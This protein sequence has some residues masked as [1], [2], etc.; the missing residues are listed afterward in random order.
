MPKDYDY[1][2]EPKKKSKYKNPDDML[3][4]VPGVDPNRHKR[5]IIGFVTGIASFIIAFIF[6]IWA[7]IASLALAGTGLGLTLSQRKIKHTKISSVALWLNIA[8][9]VIFITLIALDLSTDI[10]KGLYS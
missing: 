8:G 9:I 6:I 5:G 10:F 2:E 3:R 7:W 1:E 4:T